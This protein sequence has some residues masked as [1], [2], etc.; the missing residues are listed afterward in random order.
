MLWTGDQYRRH[1]F[2]TYSTEAAQSTI[3]QTPPCL[4]NCG[5]SS[6]LRSLR[7]LTDFQSWVVSGL[8]GKYALREIPRPAGENAGLRDDASP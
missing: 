4:R 2:A 3:N 8:A 1:D 7:F 6:L 5:G